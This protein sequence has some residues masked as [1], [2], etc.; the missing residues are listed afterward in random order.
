MPYEFENVEKKWQERWSVSHCFEAKTDPSK[1][2]FFCLEMFPYPSGALHMGHIRNY[3]I[4][5][6]LARF[7]RKN[8]KNVLYTI[9]FDSFG[10]P[11]EN[12]A[13][14]YKTKPHD[15]TLSNIAYMT[16]QLKRMGYSYDW[17]REA[18]TCLPEYYKWNQW[19]FLQMYKKGIV[20]QKEAPVNWCENCGTVLANEQVEEGCCWRCKNP[21]TK[22]NLK[23]WFI[24][25]TDYAQELL[26]DIEKD[27]GGW[28][29]RVRIMQT[30][31][32][33]RSEGAKLSFKIPE[34]DYELEAFTTR[35]DTI[36][37]VTFI[38]L[39][40]EHELVKKM[41]SSMNKDD[42]EKL[43]E[44]VKKVTS[45]SSIERS[46]AKAEKLGF[47][48]PFYGINPVNGKKIPIWIANYI[49]ID[50]GT[51]AIMGVPAHDTR[52]F[53]FCR[54]YNIPIIPVINPENGEKLDGAT[55][56]EAFT[57]D[58]IACNSGEFDGL[59][60]SEA[61]K[62][63]IDWGEEKG[64][65]KREVN[66]KLRDWL[67]SR[68]R[69]WGTPIPFVYCDKCG[70]VPVP[71][72]DLPV[73]LPEDV[74]VKEVGHSPLLDRPDFLNTT[75]PH[76]G[77]PA[78]READTMDTFFCSSW[79]FDRYCSP[80]DDKRPFEKSDVD[81]WMP[82]DQY[83][84]GIE[85]ACLHLIYA[86]FFAKFLTDIGLTEYREPFTRL[87]TQGM[88]IKD[89]AKMSKS[90]GNTVDP[91][92]IVKKYGADTVRLFIL[93]AAPPNNDLEWSDRNVEGAHRFLNRVWR[94]V[95][96]N[97]EN[98]KVYGNKIILM[99]EIKVPALRDFKR[100]IHTT[101]DSVTHDIFDEKQFNTAIAR[102]MELTNTIYSLNDASPEAWE[103][104]REAV[105][106]LL[107]CLSPFCPHITEELWEMLG[108]E[109]M[110]CLEAWPVANKEAM[111][112]DSVTIVGQINGKVRG[113]FERPAGMLKEELEKSI[114]LEPFMIEKLA[115]K[116]VVKVISVPNKLVNIVVKG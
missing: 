46:D 63:M 13:I 48:T 64:I 61:I 71:E 14:K 94:Y 79:Y 51:G 92:E 101:I 97:C 69:Y 57:E 3:S 108:H 56:K 43:N 110:L 90:L 75:C 60:T 17:K 11:A 6:V 31:W 68:Q 22:K 44:F 54:K 25:I 91:T 74:E 21:V 116:E 100:K 104:K 9:G 67:I 28:P 98:L 18:I 85:H 39:A 20:F 102:L 29:N 24:K 95:E 96:E 19:I 4:G 89:G 27:L 107:N 59:K 41:L 52:D 10:M 86:R 8:G 42:S 50:Y 23:Q 81:Y 99:D 76:C 36:Y 2:K 115:G 93:F 83:I 82:V 55:M 16:E 103:L 35:F 30:N 34:L 111:A 87:L 80:G 15:W 1:E 53:D 33:G 72:E 88:V 5:D 105:D 109:K 7:L 26:D 38:A 78:R 70:V 47:K 113:K 73:R 45:Q 62:K 49:L 40:P 58:G 32:I 12:A 65:C 114:L 66:F 37:G 112:Q 77:G 106:T 84:G